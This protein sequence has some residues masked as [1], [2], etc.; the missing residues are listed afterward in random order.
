MH[1]FLVKQSHFF[2]SYYSLHLEV[3]RNWLSCFIYFFNVTTVPKAWLCHCIRPWIQSRPLQLDTW[4]PL[5]W[6]QVS[7]SCVVNNCGLPGSMDTPAS[8]SKYIRLVCPQSSGVKIIYLHWISAP[9][10]VPSLSMTCVRVSDCDTNGK[11]KW[12]IYFEHSKRV[13]W[14]GTIVLF[15]GYILGKH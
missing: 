3:W 5:D 10:A 14:S 7:A 2:C 6:S 11:Q 9:N 1:I 15:R 12:R 4:P 13:L 8:D